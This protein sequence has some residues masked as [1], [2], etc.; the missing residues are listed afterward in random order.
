MKKIA[1]LLPLIFLS[2]CKESIPTIDELAENDELYQE[3]RLE[4]KDKPMDFEDT[5]CMNWRRAADKRK[6]KNMKFPEIK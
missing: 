4:C 2:A 1:F 5:K 3:V 6:L